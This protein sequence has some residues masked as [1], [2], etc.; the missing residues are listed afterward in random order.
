[1]RR[2]LLSA[3]GLL[4]ALA[5]GLQAADPVDVSVTG[6]GWVGNRTLK[7]LV[8]TLR[9][10]ETV[11]RTN[12]LSFMEDA[13][14][15]I[16]N[17]LRQD[18]FLQPAVS[19]EASYAQAP[20]AVF[21]WDAD[22]LRFKPEPPESPGE[23]LEALR[24]SVEP[25]LRFFFETIHLE[26]TPI[27][28]ADTIRSY[29]YPQNML[30]VRKADRAFS[31]ASLQRG[32]EAV[33]SAL[34]G[35][36][37]REAR[38]QATT[39]DRNGET[40]AVAITLDIQA[41]PQFIV[42]GET[43]QEP[44]SPPEA[45]SALKPRQ[46]YTRFWQQDRLADIRAA[47]HARGYPEP[48]LQA[49]FQ[50]EERTETT[51]RG[52]VVYQG[53]PGRQVRVAGV[54][55]NGL[56]LTRASPLRRRVAIQP[57]DRLDPGAI[58]AARFRLARLGIFERISARTEPV[59]PASEDRAEPGRRIVFDVSERAPW[60]VD[61]IVGWG[62]YE[63]LRGGFE[64]RAINLWGRAHQARL[65]AIQ[66]LRSSR[67]DVRYSLPELFGKSL[68][69]SL[70]IEGLVREEV[71]F[72]REEARLGLTLDGQV[73]D[74]ALDW[75]ASYNLER[76]NAQDITRGGTR[77][78]DNTSRAGS[79]RFSVAQDFRDSVLYPTDGF[80]W[81]GELNWAD[82]ILGGRTTFQELQ[83]TASYHRALSDWIQ[84]NVGLRHRSVLTLGGASGELPLNVRLFPGGEN[85]IRGYP[86]GEAAPRSTDGT[87]VGAETATVLHL[88]TEVG[89]LP[90]LA[91]VL[92]SDTLVQGT[93]ID[94]WPGESVLASL[95]AGLRYRTFLGPIR[96]EYG[97][98]LNPRPEDPSGT[99]HLSLGFPF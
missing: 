8:G 23:G 2:R 38:V 52:T 73:N 94:E 19:V 96:L 97:H 17:R 71:T 84:L 59:D 98:N 14:I 6:Y 40:G 31:P 48:E 21:T 33:R 95:G 51:V 30:L 61:L 62:S 65:R 47:L 76:L 25:G 18:G 56:E 20:P 75:A 39:V 45:W 72:D 15:L 91:W 57:G 88:E 22:A 36:G 4:V 34:S 42:T 85:S 5:A 99:W 37:Y 43:W 77:L 83:V 26:G 12:P 10:G 93:A 64:A 68:R 67:A 32:V 46:P 69:A 55:F 79:L 9:T 90:G 16:R 28:E 80:R 3:L 81:R 74:W 27:L 89:L 60:T 11:I 1:M 70:N 66:S 49:R 92:F 35:R 58:E 78:A 41:G 54:A 50:P 63:L 13:S 53:K 82:P 7:N 29:F 24:F 87:L 44:L 86:E